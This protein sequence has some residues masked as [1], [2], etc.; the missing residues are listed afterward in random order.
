GTTPLPP[1]SGPALN[2]N[3]AASRHPINPN[4]YGMSFA[5]ES[6]AAEL[7]LPLR[8]WGGNSTTRYNWQNDTENH[9][10]DWFFENIVEGNDPANLPDG[11]ATDRFVE[12]NRRTGTQTLLT[13]P[14]I[15]WTPKDRSAT[16]G[17]SV[18][19]Y[20]AQQKT[21]QWRP[22]CGNG[23]RTDGSLITG[24]DPHDTS[25]AIGPSFVEEWMAHLMGRYGTAA[26]GGV[27]FY[28]LD[29]EP[30][31]WNSTHRDVHPQPTSYDEMKDLTYTYAPA[32]KATDPGAK[33]CGPAL[34]GWSAY[35]WSALDS[36][37]GGEWWNHPKDRLAHGNVP[38]VEW[39]LQ[40]M[41][42]YEQEH[43]TRILDY[44][45]LHF[46]PQADGVFSNNAGGSDIQAFRLRSTRAL[47]DRN[48]TDESWIATPVYLIPRMK[49][50]V[51]NNYP[52]TKLTIGEYSWGAMGHINGALA[53]ADVL[54][55]FGREGLDMALLWGPPSSTQPGA[56]AFRMY[57]N[58]D[59]Q[60]GKFGN[61][62]VRAASKN[63]DRLAVYAAQRGSDSALTLMIVNKGTRALTSP[64]NISGFAPSGPAKVYLYSS[65]DQSRI[66]S[67]PDKAVTATGFKGTF[68]ANSITLVVI[69]GKRS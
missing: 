2:V 11:S 44:L 48:Y 67:R 23:V 15:G 34:W 65:D 4:I 30:M 58:Y 57:L 10:S 60:G 14:L 42:A 69:P 66:V 38:F 5:E 1:V 62:S 37:E 33:T 64:V 28:N 6:L 25:I 19:K 43:S 29:N 50:W 16:C 53:Q 13:V 41:K 35:F 9:A 27:R 68:P 52:G 3:V 7:K 21:D 22:D 24:N 8:R 31:L 32:I 36:A 56:F 45:D 40:Q 18:R 51:A 20:G 54:G 17:Y 63:Q 49:E 46:Y 59:G 39:Y 26:K 47:W 12:Q 55:I 61:T